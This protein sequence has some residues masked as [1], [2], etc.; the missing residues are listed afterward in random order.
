M[1][2]SGGVSQVTVDET[3]KIVEKIIKDY[4]KELTNQN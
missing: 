2:A 3:I 4:K 1:R